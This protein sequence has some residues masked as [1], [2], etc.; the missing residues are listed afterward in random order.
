ML[1][2][3]EPD[4][5]EHPAASGYLWSSGNPYSQNDIET[6]E[7]DVVVGMYVTVMSL[8]SRDGIRTTKVESVKKLKDKIQ[9]KTRNSLYYVEPIR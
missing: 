7:G 6:I 3:V 1:T 5:S 9:F 8:S 2:K 4:G